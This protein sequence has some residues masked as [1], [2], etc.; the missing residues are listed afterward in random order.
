[1]QVPTV[2][3][4]VLITIDPG[5]QPGTLLRLRGKGM[6]SLNHYGNGD[7]IV[8]ISVYVPEHLTSEEKRAIEAL[9]KSP[10]LIPGEETSRRIFN[11]R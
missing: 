2:D 7:L 9:K 5:T 3:G 8:N 11:R 1:M 6:P 10:G 4:R